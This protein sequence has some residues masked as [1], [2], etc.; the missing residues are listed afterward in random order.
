MFLRQLRLAD[1]E[2]YH[3][4]RLVYLRDQGMALLVAEMGEI[5]PRGGVV[6]PD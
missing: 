6:G 2:G 3:S 4:A 1:Q 5:D